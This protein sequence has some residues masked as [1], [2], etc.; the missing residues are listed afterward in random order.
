M[1][2]KPD[3]MI[4]LL[5]LFGAVAFALSGVPQAIKS[6]REGHSHG[7]AH[8]TVL[9]WLLGEAAMLAYAVGKYTSDLILMGNYAAN[10]VVV[11][12]IAWFKY[13]PHAQTGAAKPSQN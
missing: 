13:R 1:L 8:G 4:E 6:W 12:V 10:F 9:L 5:G 2:R 7:V 3:P 11:G